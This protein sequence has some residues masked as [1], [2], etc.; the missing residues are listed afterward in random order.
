MTAVHEAPELVL[1]SGLLPPNFYSRTESNRFA[2]GFEG[3]PL[4]DLLLTSFG[5]RLD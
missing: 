2:K 5:I 1:S 4:T 3:I